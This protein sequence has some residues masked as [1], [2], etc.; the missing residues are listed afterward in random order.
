MNM[1]EA[2]GNSNWWKMRAKRNEKNEENVNQQDISVP[3]TSIYPLSESY[4]IPF[5]FLARSGNTVKE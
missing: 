1:P 2:H 4:P 5:H 3:R